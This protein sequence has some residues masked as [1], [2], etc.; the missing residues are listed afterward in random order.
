MKLIFS[1]FGKNLTNFIL[2]G[3]ISSIIGKFRIKTGQYINYS[4]LTD[5]SKTTEKNDFLS[6]FDLKVKLKTTK[7]N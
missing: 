1:L 6:N 2:V 7:F 4:F 5:E 3:E